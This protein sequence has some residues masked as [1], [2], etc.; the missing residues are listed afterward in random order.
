MARHQFTQEERR[1][2]FATLVRRARR[3]PMSKKA[4]QCQYV[5]DR[6]ASAYDRARFA[7]QGRPVAEEEMP[8]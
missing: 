7:A 6:L 4:R 5:L 3:L 1:R 8:L 2:G